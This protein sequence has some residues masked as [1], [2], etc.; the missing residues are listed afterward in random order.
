MGGRLGGW[1]C[2]ITGKCRALWGFLSYVLYLDLNEKYELGFLR[3]PREGVGAAIYR[4]RWSTGQGITTSL[5]R[6]NSLDHHWM[7][8]PW[9]T[10]EMDSQ[11]WWETDVERRCWWVDP[12]GWPPYRWGWPACLYDRWAPP[13]GGSFWTPS[14]VVLRRFRELNLLLMS[15]CLFGEY[16]GG[17]RDCFL[18]K[19]S[20]MY[21]LTKAHRIH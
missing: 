18:D 2:Q 10:V 19:S 3:C 5:I 1:D 21:I 13:S 17:P 16:D 8:R 14:W 11:R 7:N 12:I 6:V 9:S 20:Y 4:P 15:V